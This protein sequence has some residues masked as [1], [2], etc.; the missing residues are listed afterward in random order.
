MIIVGIDEVGRG[1]WAGPL[2]VGAVILSRERPITGLLD[3]KL[4]SKASRV[5]L[6]DMINKQA[7][8]VGLGFVAPEEVDSLGLTMATTLACERA[9]EQISAAYD[10]II[11][12]GSINYLPDEPRARA[13]IKADNSVP[14]A[15]A[16]SI[17]AKVARD[18]HMC[19]VAKQHPLF[20]FDKHVGYGTVAHSQ[21]LKLHGITILHRRSF[22]PIQAL[23]A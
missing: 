9:L 10:K 6:A 18:R 13:V 21:A 19:D 12:D 14:A 11:I 20:G 3:S 17:V 22:K 2:V 7:H 8:A 16:A 23:L 15:S 4:L 5:F 1:A